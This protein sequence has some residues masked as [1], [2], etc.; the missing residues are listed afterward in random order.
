MAERGQ[1]Q[2]RSEVAFFPAAGGALGTMLR[3]HPALLGFPHEGF[4]DLQFYNLMD[5]AVPLPLDR[6][7][8]LQP[9]VG[10]IRTTA[11]FL[12]KSKDLSRVGYV[13]EAKVGAGR[14]LVTTLRFREHFDEAYPE[15]IYLFDRLLRYAT[16]AAFAP[17]RKPARMSSR[18]LLPPN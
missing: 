7:T 8:G 11:G 13:F 6:W 2:A 4:A 12:S 10:G 9:I 15:A 18:A 1:T 3:D 17:A 5:G 14:L 16:S